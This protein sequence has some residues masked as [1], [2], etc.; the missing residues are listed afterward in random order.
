[1]M[2]NKFLQGDLTGAQL[3]CGIWRF[4]RQ[5]IEVGVLSPKVNTLQHN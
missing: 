1:M 3:L 2:P 4:R 5:L